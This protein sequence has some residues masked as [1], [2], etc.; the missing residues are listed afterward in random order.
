MVT[1]SRLGD[2]DRSGHDGRTAT[3]T[4]SVVVCAFNEERYLAAC[5]HSVHAQTRPPD[6]VLLVNNASRDRSAA[7]AASIPGVR[8]IDEPRKG[9]TRARE[10]GRAASRGDILLFLDA[11]CRAPLH[12]VERVERRFLKDPSLLALSGPYRF[13]DWDLWGRTLMRAYD[14]VLAPLTQ[15][16][17]RHLLRAGAVLYGGNFAVRRAAL[18]AVGGFDTSIAFYGEDANL[19]RRL[20]A[21]GKVKLAYE[22]YLHTS[23]RR[24]K[25]LGRGRVFRLYIRNF[26]SEVLRHRPRDH[27]YVD[28]RF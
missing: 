25:A 4:L 26:V 20:A 15:L 10:A 7:V 6:E 23:A 22:C 5:L 24:Y 19:G 3:P 21:V 27:H 18:D 12:W 13:Y 9:L 28:V 17:A 8:V 14:L 1:P 16:L 2:G 11:D